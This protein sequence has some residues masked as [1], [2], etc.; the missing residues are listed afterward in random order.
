MLL[1]NYLDPSNHFRVICRDG[2]FDSSLF[3]ETWSFCLFFGPIVAAAQK[4]QLIAAALT[5]ALTTYPID[6]AT[7]ANPTF[8]N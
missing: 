7:F 4:K 6:Q 2:L 1:W 3:T 5:A 8:D